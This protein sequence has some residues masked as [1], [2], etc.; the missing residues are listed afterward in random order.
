MT[1]IHHGQLAVS[2]SS[3]FA[4][5]AEILDVSIVTRHNWRVM[6][7]TSLMT[8]ETVVKELGRRIVDL[9]LEHNLTQAEMAIEAGIPKRTVE[10]IEAGQG[11]TQL[12]AFVRVCRVLGL[13]ERLNEF[14]PESGPAPMD[15][16][17]HHGRQ[18]QRASGRR[19]RNSDSPPADR[20]WTWGDE[21]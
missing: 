18:R 8:N 17:K 21:T 14:V 2:L 7:V 12:G 10:R 11:T 19:S 3:V 4:T 9:R 16:L 5:D 13:L 15:L 1:V 20:P 6:N